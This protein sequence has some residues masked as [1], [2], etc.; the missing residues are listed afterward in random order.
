MNIKF[1]FKQLVYFYEPYSTAFFIFIHL[2]NTNRVKIR[3][4]AMH[5]IQQGHTYANTA[6][7]YLVVLSNPE[8]VTPLK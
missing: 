5:H 2:N 1:I 4:M 3:L 6:K 8:W 7:T